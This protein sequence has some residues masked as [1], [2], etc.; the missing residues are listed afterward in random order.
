MQLRA[1]LSNSAFDPETGI[2]TVTVKTKRG[3]YTGIAKVHP[4]DKEI[5]SAYTGLRIAEMKAM[6]KA[7]KNTDRKRQQYH[8]ATR[9]PTQ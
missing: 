1:K 9:I 3:T 4:E 8:P 2:S 7:Y 6:R 5:Q